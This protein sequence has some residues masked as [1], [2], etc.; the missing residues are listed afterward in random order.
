MNTSTV[1]ALSFAKDSG[2]S[3][4]KVFTKE[5][6]QFLV[7]LHRTFDNRRK[8]LLSAR[9]ERQKEINQGRHPSFLQETASIRQD[10]SWHIAP[11]PLD[12]K[13]RWVEI[14]G[15]TDR[16]MMINALN[17]GADI[18]M[19]D[20]EDANSPTWQNMVEGQSNLMDAVAGTLSYTSPEGKSYRLNDHRAAIMVRP[21]GWHLNEKH[22]L[23]DGELISA[24]LFDFGL[25]FFHN[26]KELLKKGSGPYFYLPKLENHL[27]ARLWNDVFIFS[28]KECGLANGTIRVTVLIET[29][30]AAFEMEEILY[31]LRDHIS[32][33]NAG[34]WDYI[35]SII[36]KFSHQQDLIFP[37]R[38][39]ITMT[40][41]F[42]RAYTELLVKT[43]HKRGAY[44]MGGMAAFIPSRKDPAV[45]EKAL[46][47]VRED[48]K[49]ESSDGFDGT[50]V[51]HPDLVP[52]AR[53][54]FANALRKQ[55][56]QLKKLRSD[57]NVLPSA[58]LNFHI[59]SGTI[60]EPGLR[61]NVSVALQYLN[62]WLSG[63]GAAAIFNL[64][65][66]A[67]T[68]EISRAQ[69]WQWIHHPKG[70]LEDGR[71]ITPELYKQIADEET[72]KVQALSQQSH[73][74][75]KIN[76]ARQVLDKLVL[77]SEFS[78]FLTISAYNLLN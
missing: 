68:A 63:T 78:D 67:A 69:L 21:R 64:M 16:K 34:R 31:E 54:I 41:P 25:A 61:Q 33:L 35:F 48:K 26:A 58:L 1:Q 62:A 76:E 65:E 27:E 55:D 40:V 30:L 74:T 77:N 44:A 28:Q 39:Q 10:S 73:A 5:A 57:V 72:S 18:F 43:C 9:K 60:T 59:A 4:E 19:A 38:S 22:V 12:L 6:V 7:K 42:M 37:D 49:R 32:G 53:E 29:I 50:W 46:N 20:F 14:T 15:P 17:S 56:N 75:S 52:V 8:Q 51:A 13:K 66:D 47:Q 11:I 70:I 24:S 36:K 2:V 3:G 45:N 23:V 71:R